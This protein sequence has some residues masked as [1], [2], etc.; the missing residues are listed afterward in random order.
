MKL[1]TI[2]SPDSQNSIFTILASKYGYQGN[3]TIWI[4]GVRDLSDKKWYSMSSGKKV[5]IYKDLAWVTSS[6]TNA[7]RDCLMATNRARKGG[8]K[9]DGGVCSMRKHFVCE[10]IR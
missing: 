2:D 10:F 6:N 5:P 4:D 7:T 9:V 3:D 8:F 1:F